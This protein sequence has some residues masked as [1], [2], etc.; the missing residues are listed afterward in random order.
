MNVGAMLLQRIHQLMLALVHRAQGCFHILGLGDS[1]H[2]GSEEHA[3]AKRTA[4]QE[5]IS[6][7]NSPFG[8]GS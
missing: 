8:P 4:Q 5:R 1:R 2:S 3:D 6:R 7:L